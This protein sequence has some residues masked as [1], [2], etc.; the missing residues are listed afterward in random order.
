M[1]ISHL[2]EKVLITKPSVGT[3]RTRFYTEVYRQNEEKPVIIKRALALRKTLE[4]M[5][6]FIDEGE[7]I[8]GNHSSRQRAAP[9]FP[10]YAVDWL[11]QEMDELDKRPGDAFFI[12]EDHKKELAGIADWWKGKA[13]YDCGRALMSQELQELLDSAIIKATGNLT[14]GDAH[15]AVDFYKISEIGLDGYLNEILKYHSK[16]DRSF[17]EDI[18]KDHFYTAL[19]ISIKAFRSFILRFS[20]LAYE[21]AEPETIACHH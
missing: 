21:L 10:E 14:S 3:E 4:E 13:L 18:R 20:I 9:I 2:R 11:P 16:I 5:T 17:P 1:R 19:T 7:L 6:I 8:V 15:I 12:T